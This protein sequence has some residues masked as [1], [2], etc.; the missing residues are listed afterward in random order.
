MHCVSQYFYECFYVLVFQKHAC[1]C[2]WMQVLIWVGILYLCLYICDIP[3]HILTR[4]VVQNLC[5]CD[6]GVCVM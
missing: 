3:T 2:I 6:V 1:V 5:A 4:R